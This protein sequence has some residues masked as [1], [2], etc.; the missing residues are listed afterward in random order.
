MHIS[1]ASIERALAAAGSFYSTEP[2][3]YRHGSLGRQATQEDATKL[4][5]PSYQTRILAHATEVV[6]ECEVAS[7]HARSARAKLVLA[8]QHFTAYIQMHQERNEISQ[9]RSESILPMFVYDIQDFLWGKTD[10]TP[11]TAEQ[12]Q[13]L[14]TSFVEGTAFFSS[15][16]KNS[17]LQFI[18]NLQAHFQQ[19][20]QIA[21]TPEGLLTLGYSNLEDY[22]RL[23]QE[24]LQ[25]IDIIA[26]MQ[27]DWLRVTRPFVYGR[28][29]LSSRTE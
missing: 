1:V 21:T 17:L 28:E 20:R 27:N 2:E 8:S 10:L 16:D 14:A 26:H 12:V 13:E 24:R 11:L 9:K 22:K 23:Y 3:E 15:G 29:E 5:D 7:I 19:F 4:F 25:C 18:D 6:H